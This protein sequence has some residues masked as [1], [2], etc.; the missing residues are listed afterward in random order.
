M[1]P[2]LDLSDQW[3]AAARLAPQLATAVLVLALFFVAGRLAG[4]AFMRVA[5]RREAAGTYQRFV[6]GTIVWTVR[7]VGV[8]LALDI[9]GLERFFAGLLAGGGMTAIVL[10]FAFR[11]IGENLL[12]GLFL[13]FSR[14]FRLGDLIRSAELEGTV[15]NIDLRSTHVRSID[16]RDIYI[17][18]SQIFNRPLTNYTRDG[19]RRPAFTFGIDYRDDAEAARLAVA[20]AVRGVE[21]VLADPPVEVALSALG[22]SYVELEATFWISTFDQDTD[23]VR[24]RS[25]AMDATRRVLLAGGFTVSAEVTTPLAMS[26][27]K[28]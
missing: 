22:P 9:L 12:A 7:L 27:Q 28:R 16:G 10:G 6:R 18:N 21:G 19:L 26:R 24:I 3:A 13:A 4:S 8:A 14:P 5:A 1:V 20:E 25:R 2:A 23:I 15:R 11:E 17:P